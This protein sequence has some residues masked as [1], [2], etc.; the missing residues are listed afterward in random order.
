MTSAAVMPGFTSI[1]K[2]RVGSEGGRRRGPGK[3]LPRRC[4]RV[5][6]GVAPVGVGGHRTR[7]G[8][9]HLTGD[10]LGI[11]S[12]R[13]TGCR[14]RPS[15]ERDSCTNPKPAAIHD[16]GSGRCSVATAALTSPSSTSSTPRLCGSPNSTSPSPASSPGTGLTPRTWATSPLLTGAR[17][18]PWTSSSAASPART[19]PPSASAPASRQAPA[20]DCGHTWPQRST[21]SSLNGS[22][23]RTSAA[24]CPHPPRG[25]PK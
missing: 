20:R 18:S 11:G 23:S 25:P 15:P 1:C 19:C 13:G 8:V 12:R 2:T 22:S 21:R 5:L 7:V 10:Q 6:G 4:R 24:C 16:S 9:V 3:R 17:S 14:G